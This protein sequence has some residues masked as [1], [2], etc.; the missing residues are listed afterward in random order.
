MDLFFLKKI[1][2]ALIM[3]LS[4]VLI[5]LFIAIFLFNKK[6]KLSRYAL[7]T[8]TV[9]LFLIS[10]PP[11]SDALIE[12]LEQKYQPFSKSETPIGYIVVLGCANTENPELP[13]NSRLYPC[14]LERAVEAYRIHTLHPEAKIIT[15]GSGFNNE[16]SNAEIVRDT[17]VLLG[18]DADKIKTE[19]RPKD[20][21]EEAKL[22]SKHVLNE[23]VVLVTN[24]NH[25]PRSMNYFIEHGVNVTAAPT[26]YYV[27][28]FTHFNRQYDTTNNWDYY[29]PHVRKT[30]QTT[31][32]W[33]EWLGLIVQWL[34]S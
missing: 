4:M 6:P 22:I 31:V 27:R 23:Q 34:K 19:G 1:I 10:Y 30:Q 8:A 7:I 17:L 12:P 28:Q 5:L 20:T 26:G 9:S 11:L 32:V 16:F 13:V 2:S 3:P 18:V 21:G 25:M 15:S 33:Y 29:V 24:A 14:S